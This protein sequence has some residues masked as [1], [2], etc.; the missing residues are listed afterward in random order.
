VGDYFVTGDEQANLRVWNSKTGKLQE[1]IPAHDGFVWDLAFSSDGKQLATASA[2]N[3]FKIWRTDDWL[4]QRSVKAHDGELG[5]VRFSDDGKYLVSAGDDKKV[6]LWNLDSRKLE[7]EFEGHRTGVWRAIFSPTNPDLIASCSYDGEIIFW[8][9]GAENPIRA[10]IKAHKNQI[11]GLAFTHDGTRVVSASDDQTIKIWDVETGIELFVLRDTDDSAIVAVSFSNDG[12][13]LAS[14]NQEGW[15]TI[16]SA[17]KLDDNYLPVLPM[18]SIQHAQ[19]ISSALMTECE[20]EE[21]YQRE[22]EKAELCSSHFPSYVTYYCEGV[23]LYRLG[24]IEES[25]Q[26]L[27]EAQRLEPIMYGEP[28]LPPYI[29]GYLALAYLKQGRLEESR[30]AEAVFREKFAAK[31]WND[32]EPIPELLEEIESEKSSVTVLD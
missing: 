19:D 10:R 17:N 26:A 24:R 28:D 7:F 15:V 16:R 25:I 30:N 14:G 22:L 3:T 31:I 32:S 6:K 12:S 5:S 18:D 29:E 13:I 1:M 23:A 4:E 2:D 11:A 9:I 20:T 8:E 27:L 21:D